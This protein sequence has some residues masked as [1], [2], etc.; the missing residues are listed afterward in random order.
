MAKRKPGRPSRKWPKY[1]EEEIKRMVKKINDS[2]YRLEKAGL[3]SYSAEYRKIEKYAISNPNG[4]GK[5]YNVNE[6]TGTIRVTKDLSR[7]ETKKER[8]K[9]VEIL[10]NILAA[11][12]RTVSGTRK[13][14]KKGF[15]T[16]KQLYGYKGTQKQYETVWRSYRDIIASNKKSKVG[17]DKVMQMIEK[18]NLYQLSKS[19]IRKT[20]KVLSR[21]RSADS[22]MRSALRQVKKLKIKKNTQKKSTTRNSATPKKNTNRKRK[23]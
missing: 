18:T 4:T 15:E 11:E 23:K 9:F 1:S 21:A 12:T 16:V 3:Q 2:L 19:D 17:S 13:A 20:M 7:F 22:G 6:L 14:M 8:A 10:E 5:M